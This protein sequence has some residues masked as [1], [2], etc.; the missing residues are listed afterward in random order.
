VLDTAAN[1]QDGL[2]NGLGF[3]FRDFDFFVSFVSFCSKMRIDERQAIHDVLPI[4][5]A[6]L[7]IW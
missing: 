6:Q 3:P 1:S 2:D 7:L 4:H 5:K